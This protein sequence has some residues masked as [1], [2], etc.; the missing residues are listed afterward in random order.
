MI[1]LH[2]I[3]FHQGQTK[4]GQNFDYVIS[5]LKGAA[6][7]EMIACPLADQKSSSLSLS[8]YSNYNL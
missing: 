6:M 2:V 8:A 4:Y 7:A 3:L 5:S 1:F